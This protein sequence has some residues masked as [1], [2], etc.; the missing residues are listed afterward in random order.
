MTDDA[1]FQAALSRLNDHSARLSPGRRVQARS[2]VAAV[3]CLALHSETLAPFVIIEVGNGTILAF[4]PDSVGVVPGTRPLR[5]RPVS[6]WRHKKGGLYEN[7]GVTADETPFVLYRDLKTA[8]CWI[9]PE[10][11]FHDGR[12]TLIDRKEIAP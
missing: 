5:E 6:I 2:S 12:F 1:E 3:L 4:P 11:M 7:L 8:L 10:P 9:R